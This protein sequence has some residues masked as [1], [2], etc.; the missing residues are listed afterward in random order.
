MATEYRSASPS[1]IVWLAEGPLT[2]PLIAFAAVDEGRPVA[3]Y[4][5]AWKFG[6]CD[7]WFLVVDA[8][9]SKRSSIR[10]VRQARRMLNVA[11]ALGDA[12]VY[13]IRDDHPNSQKL[14]ETVG[15]RFEGVVE[16]VLAD[17]SVTEKEE[18]V[19]G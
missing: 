6:R 18:W 15:F 11:R 19:H 17:G 12:R 3:Y 8:S 16:V 13:C 1:E 2:F 9:A 5:L 10:V 4:G 7:L 14:L